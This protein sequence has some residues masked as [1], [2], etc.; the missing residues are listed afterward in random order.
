[1]SQATDKQIAYIKKLLGL[2]NSH[3]DYN[4]ATMTKAQASQIIDEL[5]PEVED[6]WSGEVF[7]GDDDEYYG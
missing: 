2:L 1:M 4:Y 6:A 7:G 3:R 5:K